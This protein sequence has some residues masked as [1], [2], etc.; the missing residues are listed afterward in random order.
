MT[1]LEAKISDLLDDATFQ[2]IDRSIGRFNLFEAMGAVRAELRH[3]NF[4]GF[5]LSPVRN[6]GCGALVLR[7]FLR[8]IL[9]KMPEHRRPVRALEIL[10]GDLE[11]AV[12]HREWNN[13]DLFIE[14]RNLNFVVAIENKIHAKVGEGQLSRYKNIVT[15][16][17]PQLRHLFVFL[18][19]EGIGPDDA[20]YVPFS[21]A[22]L[23][24]CIY[25]I[26]EQQSEAASDVMLILR[27]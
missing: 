20:D 11:N 27:H 4:L 19:P 1:D 6:H 9:S 15:G 25:E 10:V 8:S 21:Y 23:A 14:I 13:I 5:L 22:E 16:K 18:T 7:A 12:V 26:A 3:S 2:G 17:Y 24:H